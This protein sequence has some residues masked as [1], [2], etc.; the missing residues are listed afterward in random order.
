MRIVFARTRYFYDSYIDFYN[1][2]SLSGYSTCYIDEMN[3]EDSRIT[4]ITAPMNGELGS[5]NDET[6]ARK[7]AKVYLWDLERPSGSG[8]LQNYINDNNKLIEDGFL[9]NILVSDKRLA[10]DTRFRYIPLGSHPDL[11]H[12]GGLSEKRYDVVHLMSYTGRRSDPWFRDPGIIRE[13]ID[14]LTVAPNGWGAIKDASLQRS[15]LMVNIHQDS[16][17]YLEPLRF[18]L[19]M[20][21][22]LPIVTETCYDLSQYNNCAG[23]F[24]TDKDDIVKTI[25]LVLRSYPAVYQA[26]ILL[27]NKFTAANTFCSYLEEHI[28]G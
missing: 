2:V 17:M 6:R 8:G 26:G 11:G 16:S 19:A 5:W 12:P 7:R 10:Q 18:S 27:R 3:L 25:K 9:D 22:G 15:K 1:L 21:Y 24:Q 28:Y 23:I 20:A 13:N 14:G 4:Y